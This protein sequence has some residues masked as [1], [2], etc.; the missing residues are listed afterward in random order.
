MSFR[1]IYKPRSWVPS[2]HNLDYERLL[3]NPHCVNELEKQD[4]VNV[5]DLSAH[6]SAIHLIEDELNNF[7][8]G[9]T[10]KNNID[11]YEIVN[12]IAACHLFKNWNKNYGVYTNPYKDMSYETY[13]NMQKY[14]LW[15][16]PKANVEDLYEYYE[17]FIKL[18]VIE[19]DICKY[20]IARNPNAIS[21]IEQIF[22]FYNRDEAFIS[23]L[24][25]N[26]NAVHLLK[27]I[28]IK[29]LDMNVLVTNKNI[30]DIISTRKITRY[31]KDSH[32][33]LLC[34]NEGTVKIM[35]KYFYDKIDWYVMCENPSDDAAE[36]LIK[37][38]D[39][40]KDFK[41]K[42]ARN[43]N[44]KV[45]KLFKELHWSTTNNDILYN[46]ISGN[47][48]A[49]EDIEQKVI[50]DPN[51]LYTIF[52]LDDLTENPAIFI[53]DTDAMKNQINKKEFDED[54]K[55]EKQSFVEELVLHVLTPFRVNKYIKEYNYDLLNDTYI[56]EED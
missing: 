30:F 3:N 19:N 56:L 26:E 41:S 25:E 8:N 15:V 27:T 21:Y 43:P 28:P 2:I 10:K 50:S 6:Y 33:R 55:Y 13:L 47:P 16:E 36:L 42:L 18:D 12:N 52:N 45:Y 22:P 38:K 20:N 53:L 34:F 5:F 49:I 39:K 14:N 54:K 4:M 17:D 23:R 51:S 7:K 32:W 11:N 1:P 35:E 46:Y 31:F 44:P 37:N 9:I 48:A 24:C 40:I 29:L